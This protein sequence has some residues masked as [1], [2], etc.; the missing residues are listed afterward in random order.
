M[1]IWALTIS[2]YTIFCC[3]LPS[4]VFCCCFHYF[5]GKSNF[6]L[7]YVKYLAQKRKLLL[8]IFYTSQ[9]LLLF[10]LLLA[11][12]NFIYMK[13][14][15]RFTTTL[16]L[17]PIFVLFLSSPLASGKSY[18]IF[19]IWPTEKYKKKENIIIIQEFPAFHASGILTS[20]RYTKRIPK[21]TQYY[22]CIW[23]I[24]VIYSLILYFA[25]WKL[26]FFFL[27]VTKSS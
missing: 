11:S 27:L 24:R 5:S 23:T 8:M 22:L 2:S 12:I 14:A 1:H 17:G 6:Y 19:T 21:L 15:I 20:S 3:L 25:N 26:Y 13:H 4:R 18:P 7:W 9:H 10:F 16:Q